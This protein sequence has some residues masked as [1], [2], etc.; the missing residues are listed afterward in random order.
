MPKRILFIL[1]VLAASIFFTD[2]GKNY[3][4]S[5]ITSTV[6]NQ[7]VP[8]IDPEDL[9]AL[10]QPYVLLDLRT[11]EEYEIS[12]LKGTRFVNY[13]TFQVDDLADIPKDA[14]L[15]LY[16]AVGVRSSK[17]GVALQEA[18]Y[19]NVLNLRGGI[20][21]WVNKGF[22]VFDAKGQTERIHA[23]SRFWGFWLTKGDKVYGQ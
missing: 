8:N 7:A 9:Y 15:I 6:S 3:A 11:P 17:A 2:L 23:Y 1:V 18:G 21:N 22:P 20:F 4:Y 16:C 5:L 13:N 10:E 19:T 14:K 12:H